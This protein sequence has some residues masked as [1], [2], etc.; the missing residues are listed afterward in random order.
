LFSLMVRKIVIL[1]EDVKYVANIR[2]LDMQDCSE[3]QSLLN[4]SP[5]LPTT[6]VL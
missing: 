5:K 2:N 3:Q 4:A 6:T 1:W